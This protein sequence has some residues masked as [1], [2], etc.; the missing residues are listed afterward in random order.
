[1]HGYISFRGTPLK[2]AAAKA[3]LRQAPWAI[4]FWL[5]GQDPA[6]QALEIKHAIGRL[7]RFYC[8]EGYKID[9]RYLVSELVTSEYG[10]GL[11]LD[12]H[13]NRPAHVQTSLGKA[14]KQTEL[15]HPSEWTTK[16][17]RTLINSYLKIR[18]QTSM[19]HPAKR[20]RVTM[21]YLNNGTIS[22]RQ[23]SFTRSPSTS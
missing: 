2:T 16:D 8:N 13:V 11:I 20:A 23:G 17:E 12:Q 19:T 18:E 4:Y 6:I 1:V 9:N 5:A 21:K 3:Q 15:P 22:D 7:D 10:V 14:L